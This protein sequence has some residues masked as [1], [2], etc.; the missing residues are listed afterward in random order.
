[1]ADLPGT[2]NLGGSSFLLQVEPFPLKGSPERG[3]QERAN[4]YTLQT[5]ASVILDD[6][7]G[8]HFWYGLASEWVL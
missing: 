3:L 1:M 7:G 5:A 2:W 6:L 8:I 4:V